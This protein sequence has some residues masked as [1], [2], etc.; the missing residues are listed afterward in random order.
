MNLMEQITVY[1]RIDDGSGGIRVPLPKQVK[2][3]Y[4]HSLNFVLTKVSPGVGS[5][6]SLV[7]IY[8]GVITV[9]RIC[10]GVQQAGTGVDYSFCQNGD[11]MVVGPNSDRITAPIPTDSPFDA[12]FEVS[13]EITEF[14]PAQEVLTP[15]SWLIQAVD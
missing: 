7:V 8:G 6:V 15:V 10:A 12:R 14:D 1:E 13:L 11:Y 3:F 9:F 2:P 4:I 5:A